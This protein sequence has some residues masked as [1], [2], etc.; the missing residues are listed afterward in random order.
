MPAHTPLPRDATLRSVL[1]TL[2]ERKS[3]VPA[4]YGV[5]HRYQ[6]DRGPVVLRLGVSRLSKGKRPNYRIDDASTDALI[7]AIDGNTHQPWTGDDLN[8]S[9]DWSSA[10]MTFE[11]VKAVLADVRAEEKARR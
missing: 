4:L 7:A 11:E 10:A 6:K 1:P 5:M 8:L 9:G 2:D 3:F